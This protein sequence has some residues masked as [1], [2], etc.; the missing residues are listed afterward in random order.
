MTGVPL[1]ANPW[2]LL[3]LFA[4]PL[5]SIRHHRQL[6]VG[7]LTY[8]Q[9]PVGAGGTWRLH[10]PFYCRLLALCFLFIALAR[11]QLGFSWEETTTEGI[12]IQL[13]LDVS[14]SM[15]AEDFEPL[16]RLNVAKEVMAEFILG[17]PGDRIGLIVFAGAA[18]TKS[19][20]TTDRT[21]LTTILS[22]VELN[23]LPDGTA[24]GM[25]LAGAAARL[26]ESEAESKIVVLVTDGVNT[27]GHITPS[28]AAAVCEGLGIKVYTVAVGVQ[29]RPVLVP[30]RARDP[31]TG[32][33]I[34]KKVPSIVEVD[35]ELLQQIAER[36]GGQF[37]SAQNPAALKEIF[38]VIDELERTPIETRKIVRFQE[39]FAPLA[40]AALALLCLP[41]FT[42]FLG[43]TAEP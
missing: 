41:L 20:S 35:E 11:P 26:K 23:T 10:L 37:F 18:I 32:R 42:T 19:P 40:W 34:T 29:D 5:L 2:W 17:R 16:N 8:S 7:A 14:G 12:D 6:S 43:L 22:S 39:R 31:F 24:I 25:A 21:M 4:L 27:A 3:G 15:A 30:Q 36:T 1:L 13:A 33:I 28:S 9:L 38:A